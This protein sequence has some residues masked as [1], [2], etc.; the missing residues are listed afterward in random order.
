MRAAAIYQRDTQFPSI[1]VPELGRVQ[2]QEA[3]I[4]ANSAIANYGIVDET[5]CFW[6]GKVLPNRDRK[7]VTMGLRPTKGDEDAEWFN[8]WQAETPA[9][10]CATTVGQALSPAN[11]AGKGLASS[12][13]RYHDR[14]IRYAPSRPRFGN[15]VTYV[16]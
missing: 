15:R 1:L 3:A 14:V 4:D 10:P 16:S 11:S 7:G 9:P 13:E 6:L 2:E 5:E 12:T 8:S